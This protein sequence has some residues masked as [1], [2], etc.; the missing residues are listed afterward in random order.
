MSTVMAL[1]ALVV[2]F[3]VNAKPPDHR[4]PSAPR[5]LTVTNV[6]P[7][8]MTLNWDRSRDNVAVTGYEVYVNG[9]LVGTGGP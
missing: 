4:A 1:L 6:S 8:S 9:V 5:N 3:G 7:T 2:L